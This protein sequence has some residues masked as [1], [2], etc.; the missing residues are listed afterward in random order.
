MIGSKLFFVCV[1]FFL[2]GGRE[3]RMGNSFLWT[4]FPNIHSTGLLIKVHN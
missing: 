1:S 4:L 3:G 2:G